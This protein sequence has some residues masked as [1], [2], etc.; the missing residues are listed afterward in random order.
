MKNWIDFYKSLPD[1]V[2]NH[3]NNLAKGNL[4]NRKRYTKE[5]FEILETDPE[6][7]QQSDIK[8]RC[9]LAYIKLRD[10]YLIENK[11]F[12]DE[13][14]KSL[15]NKEDAIKFLK[16]KNLLD[17]VISIIQIGGV[18]GEPQPIK[19]VVLT[20]CGKLV[21][22]KTTTSTNA[23]IETKS[24]AGKDNLIDRIRDVCF[25]LDWNKYSN[26]SPT[27]ISYG[28]RT[29]PQITGKDKNGD[30]IVIEKTVDKKIT[31]DTI[32]Y[33][34]D[35]SQRFIDGDDFKMLCEEEDVNMP[36]TVDGRQIILK[37]KKPIVIITTADTTQSN[38]LLR[39]L[40]SIA[41]DITPEQTIKINE[42]QL[43][44]DCNIIENK[45][46]EKLLEQ[47]NI[48]REAFNHL[49]KIK[50]DLKDVK[51]EILNKKPKFNK[52][53]MRTLF[54]R[55]LDFIK[56]STALHQH[57]R[58]QIGIDG[59]YPV[60]LATIEDV[61]I[62]FEVFK[63]IYKSIYYEISLLNERQKAIHKKLREN[64][65]EF[66]TYSEIQS[67]NESEGVS[68]PTIREDIVRIIKEDKEINFEGN[69]PEKV[70]C[71]GRVKPI[72]VK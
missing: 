13:L 27:S 7:K 63:Y 32:I 4:D 23:N 17:N 31:E 2:Q 72:P 59:K 19:V 47:E 62:G 51:D 3:I 55:L 42:F 24:G 20:I 66:Y 29:E 12:Q 57:Q 10:K 37:W 15:C 34:K 67:W 28:Q 61:E 43:I 65:G 6:I 5:F 54:P 60:Y 53:E 16:D 8:K 58:E 46:D 36:K 18:V 9:N 44:R 69:Y 11:S 50:V 33:V 45:D 40:P 49:R 35:G 38:Q 22:N 41:L 71:K 56:F 30:P 39:R 26:P 68:Q 21:I 25:Y 1:D 70:G 52:V 48:A 64:P 14:P